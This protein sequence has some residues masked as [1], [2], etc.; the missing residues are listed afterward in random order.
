MPTRH[1]ESWMLATKITFE[2]ENGI[3]SVTIET[4][5]QQFYNV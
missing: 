4:I 3:A 2:C 1:I 5:I